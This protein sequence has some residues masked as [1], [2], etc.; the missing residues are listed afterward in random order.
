MCGS[1]LALDLLPDTLSFQQALVEFFNYPPSHSRSDSPKT[2]PQ[3]RLRSL[4]TISQSE[5]CAIS[6][7]HPAII[8][9]RRPA[10]VSADVP[11]DLVQRRLKKESQLTQAYSG[12]VRT[13]SAAHCFPAKYF[14]G[15]LSSLSSGSFQH[16][17]VT[18][19]RGAE[20]TRT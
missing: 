20:G 14:R 16:L 8:Q 5:R 7:A 15:S 4:S 11:R 19:S 6:Q 17:T 9:A 12:E 10:S 13:S 1:N 3:P 18:V 2:Q